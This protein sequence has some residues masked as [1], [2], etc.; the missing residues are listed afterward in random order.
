MR[1]LMIGPQARVGR[2]V[3]R[4]LWATFGS[5]VNPHTAPSDLVFARERGCQVEI[6]QRRASDLGA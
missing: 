4:R 3:D 1:E 6:G 2:I 5:L